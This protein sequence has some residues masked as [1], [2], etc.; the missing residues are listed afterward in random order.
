MSTPLICVP[1]SRASL[2]I[3]PT[4]C[5]AARHG[6][7][8]PRGA[9]SAGGHRPRTH[10]R[11]R[12]PRAAVRTARRGAVGRR[13]RRACGRRPRP[14]DATGRDLVARQRRS[15]VL[16]PL[17]L[18]RRVAFDQRGDRGGDAQQVGAGLERDLLHG[19]AVELGGPAASASPIRAL[20]F[21]SRRVLTSSALGSRSG[22]MVWR[23]ARSISRSRLRSRGDEQD[24]LAAAAGATGAADAVHV[25]LGVVGHVVV[26]HVGHALDVEAARRRRSRPGC[27]SCRPSAGRWSSRASP[28]ARRR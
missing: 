5:R 18:H 9:R 11:L 10:S 2:A 6:G 22:S 27:R 13:R 3:A 8:R 14:R 16:A 1:C 23:V 24:R 17:R 25:R 28:A 26:D 4:C 20:N 21:A 15:L 19:L 12:A 7:G